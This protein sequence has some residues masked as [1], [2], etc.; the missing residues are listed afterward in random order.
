MSKG[1]F[2]NKSHSRSC[3]STLHVIMSISLRKACRFY[4]LRRITTSKFTHKVSKFDHPKSKS[5]LPFLH[6]SNQSPTI[7]KLD[8]KAKCEKSKTFITNITSILLL[9]KV[10]PSFNSSAMKLTETNILST[11]LRKLI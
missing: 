4:L 5:H 1:N 8:S 9:Q 3:P 11:S 10:S 7:E 2:S 6:P